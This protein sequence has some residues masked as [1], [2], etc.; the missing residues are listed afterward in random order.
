MN[1]ALLML[2]RATGG[3]VVAYQGIT[4]DASDTA[5]Y[6]FSSVDI[7]GVSATRSV[8]VCFGGRGAGPT[9]INAVTIGG[10]SATI[11]KQH[12]PSVS[13][14]GIARAA[15]PTGTTADVVVTMSTALVRATLAVYTVTGAVS[16]SGSAQGTASAAVTGVSG[17]LVIG[18]AFCGSVGASISGVTADGGVDVEGYRAMCGSSTATGTVTVTLNDAPTYPDVIAVAYQPD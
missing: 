4:S 2:M 13:V 17:G 10:V 8:I 15:V 14:T 16:V 11:D 18:S 5:S 9:T 3:L 1:P 6:T 12:S 7:G